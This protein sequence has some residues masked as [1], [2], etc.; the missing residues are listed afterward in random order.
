MMT[1]KEYAKAYGVPVEVESVEVEMA[2]CFTVE[3]EDEKGH[4]QDLWFGK[5]VLSD[6]IFGE[7]VKAREERE[8]KANLAKY[9]ENFEK[10]GW[11]I[12][13]PEDGDEIEDDDAA[14]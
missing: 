2:L 14:E 8:R 11:A 12:N 6:E 13:P 1:N 7:D 10:N 9:I 3:F 4:P 5:P